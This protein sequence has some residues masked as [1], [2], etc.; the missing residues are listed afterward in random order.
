MIARSKVHNTHTRTTNIKH[1]HQVLS[2]DPKGE[3][4]NQHE[5]ENPGGRQKGDKKPTRKEEPGRDEGGEQGKGRGPYPKA[6]HSYSL[7]HSEISR[8]FSLEMFF[9]LS[10]PLEPSVQT[11][12]GREEDTPTRRREE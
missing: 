10:D 7:Q 3:T 6:K 2:T 11:V 1:P 9:H 4:K 5:S 12:E 8:S